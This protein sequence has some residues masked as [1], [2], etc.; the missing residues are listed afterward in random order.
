MPITV[1]DP[2]EEDIGLPCEDMTPDQLV[3]YLKDYHFNINHVVLKL[4]GQE[5]RRM[6]WLQDIYGPRDA[7]HIVKW[8]CQH[9]GGKYDNQL[10]THRRFNAKMKWWVDCMHMEMQQ[11][12]NKEVNHAVSVPAAGFATMDALL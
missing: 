8:V 1:I 11:A 3:V 10:V 6:K 2:L 4:D 7:G 5:Y 9:Y 12:R